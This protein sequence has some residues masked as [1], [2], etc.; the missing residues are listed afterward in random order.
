VS[1][2]ISALGSFPK[3]K[4]ILKMVQRF[5][6]EERGGALMI[7]RVVLPRESDISASLMAWIYQ[8][9]SIGRLGFSKG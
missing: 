9:I 5:V 1:N 6:F 8:S 4:P 7:S 2:I 3:I